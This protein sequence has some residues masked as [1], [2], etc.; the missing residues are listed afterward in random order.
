M[1]ATKNPPL[2]QTE[3]D[4]QSYGASLGRELGPLDLILAQIIPVVVPDFFV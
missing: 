4:V 2:L 1:A 3:A